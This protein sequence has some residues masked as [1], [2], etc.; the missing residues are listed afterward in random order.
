[1]INT[2]N[3]G[4]DALTASDTNEDSAVLLALQTRQQ[5]AASTLSLTQGADSTALAL[6]GLNR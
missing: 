3:S 4:A 5:I 1:M 2:L 6:F